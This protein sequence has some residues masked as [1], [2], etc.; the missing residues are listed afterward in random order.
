MK[1]IG[2]SSRKPSTVLLL[3]ST[4]TWVTFRAAESYGQCH[5]VLLDNRGTCVWTTCQ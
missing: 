4:R 3:L 1:T 5:I 2:D